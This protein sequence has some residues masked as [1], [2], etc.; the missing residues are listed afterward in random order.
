MS[1][2]CATVIALCLLS[3]HAKSAALMLEP[4][5]GWKDVTNS[6]VVRNAVMALKGPEASSFII[7]SAPALALD[8]P[9]AVRGYLQ[10]VLRGMRDASRKDYRSGGNVE[11]RVF[12]NGIAVELLR[13]R[14]DGKDRLVLAVFPLAGVAHV[15][16]LMSAAPEA[17]LPSLFGALQT[18]GGPGQ[19]FSS[20][21]ARSLDGQLE[22]A[23]GGGLRSRSLLDEEMAQRF[24]LG[25]Q[26]S[27]SEILFQKLSEAAAVKPAEQAANILK[28]IQASAG[29]TSIKIYPL[30]AALTSAGPI[31]IY[32][33]ALTKAGDK[34]AVGYLPW[35]YWGYRLFGRGPAA[36]ELL[37]G[38]LAA[39][40]A[41]PSSIPGLLAATP[42]IP[43][44]E[45]TPLRKLLLIALVA[46][47]FVILLYRRVMS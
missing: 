34:L 3:A 35:S 33:W 5:P 23:L 36:D 30:R 8:N 12:R 16:V 43:M 21:V 27:G 14:L 26:G 1:N 20:G 38:A 7:K 44:N 45:E 28:L 41:G 2:V 40:K 31:A 22:L 39:L 4:P 18:G 46:L 10:A 25:I 6:G 47:C 9:V 11:T 15:A 13:A 19:V 29:M 17:M 24:V 32:S 37:V 42:R